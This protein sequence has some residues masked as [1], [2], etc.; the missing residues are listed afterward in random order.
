MT[1]NDKAKLL[2]SIKQRRLTYKNS[3]NNKSEGGPI[4]TDPVIG[5]LTKEQ[6]DD[7]EKQRNWLNNW[8]N[9]RKING[10][11]INNNVDVPF[12]EDIYIDDLNYNHPK[13]KVYGEFDTVSNRIL[14]DE[15]YTDKKG[16]PSHEFSHRFQKDLKNNNKSNYNS[17]IQSPIL[18]E[19]RDVKNLSPYH[20]DVQENHAEINRFRYNNNLKPDQVITP[21]DMEGYNFEGYNLNHFDKDQMLN[22]LN[23]TADNTKP[24]T[25]NYAA[26]GGQL[27]KQNN[28]DMLNEFN[29][30]GSHEQNPLGGVPLGMG[31]NGN[32]NTIE[33]GETQKDDFIYSNRINLTSDV[34]SNFNLPKSLVG[35]SVSDATKIINNKFKDRNSQIDN[36]T[37]STLL[38]RIANAQEHIKQQEQAKMNESMQANAQDAPEPMMDA[39]EGA[40]QFMYGGK[41][42][43]MFLGGDTGVEN[44]ANQQTGGMNMSQLGNMIGGVGTA[45]GGGGNYAKQQQQNYQLGFHDTKLEK[46]Q[47]DEQQIDK[48]KDTVSSAFGPI[49]GLFRGIQKAGKGIGNSIGGESGAAVSGAFSPEEGTMANFKDKDLSVG[50]KILGTVPGVGGVMAHRQAQKRQAEFEQKRRMSENFYRYQNTQNFDDVNINAYGGKVNKYGDGGKS[51]PWERKF[52]TQQDDPN[53]GGS[54][55]EGFFK[56]IN[57]APYN[58]M[59]DEPFY[60]PKNVPL[61]SEQVLPNTNPGSARQFGRNINPHDVN[62]VNSPTKSN[63]RNIVDKLSNID[64]TALRYSPIAMNAFQLATLNK[65]RYEKLDR[66]DNQYQKQYLDEKYYENIAREQAAASTNAIGRSGISAGQMINAQIGSQLAATKGISDS[67]NK[68]KQHNINENK[69]AQQTKFNN[70]Q[71]N[72]GQSNLEND[73]NAKNEGNYETQ[74][75]KLLGQMGNDLGNVGKEE[76]YKK[77]AKETFGYTWDGKYFTN[78]KGDKLTDTEMKEKIDKDSKSDKYTKKFNSMKQIKFKPLK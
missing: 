13:S 42:N 64:G 24:S 12:S 6:T 15:S 44:N 38:D 43:K 39:P 65:P 78:D 10:V 59:N 16:I 40:E 19:L 14:F 46:D 72:I 74:K 60:Q 8:N 55:P 51:K 75:S 11:N 67:Y 1:N 4:D 54:G 20:A 56:N 21:K 26:M 35:K 25:V 49:G 3:L 71:V 37:K 27:N 53:Y 30:G 48:V 57:G 61:L 36:R 77:L 62:N 29:E 28:N 47:N 76:V 58:T 66:L 5:N 68:I 17:Y 22:L 73:I 50:E 69:I 34:I 41:Q 23:K 33:E 32:M 2:K 9:N 52:S 7:I 45:I 63:G 31:S 18:N 70:K